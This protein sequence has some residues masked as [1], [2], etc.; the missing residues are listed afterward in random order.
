LPKW[1]DLDCKRLIEALYP[2]NAWLAVLHAYASLV[3]SLPLTNNPLEIYDPVIRGNQLE[4]DRFPR[5]MEPLPITEFPKPISQL[6]TMKIT[7]A[8]PMEVDQDRE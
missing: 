2:E 5:T 1:S 6:T 3:V 7:A 4:L 8:E